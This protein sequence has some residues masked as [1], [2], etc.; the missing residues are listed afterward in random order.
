LN[1]DEQLCEAFLGQDVYAKVIYELYKRYSLPI[2]DEES[3]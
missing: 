2:L 1:D 3:K